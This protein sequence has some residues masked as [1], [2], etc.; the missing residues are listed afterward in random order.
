MACNERASEKGPCTETQSSSLPSVVEQMA[1]FIGSKEE[2]SIRPWYVEC[3]GIRDRA[4]KTSTWFCGPWLSHK[5]QV[6]PD[7][8]M[9][10]IGQTAVRKA[11]SPQ[12]FLSP[13]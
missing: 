5:T 8:A 13:V 1:T 2:K 12:Q 3:L 4:N 10:C 6:L 9:K 11:L 7:I